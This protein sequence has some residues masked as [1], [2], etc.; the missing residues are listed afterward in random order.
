MFHE[1]NALRDFLAPIKNGAALWAIGFVLL[2]AAWSLWSSRRLSK[3]VDRIRTQDSALWQQ[4]GSPQS[5]ENIGTAR[6]WSTLRRLRV[7]QLF[8]QQF[9]QHVVQEIRSLQ[10]IITRGL[11]VL[12]VAGLLVIYLVWPHR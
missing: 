10:R 4:L 9:N 8:A 3:L 12:S 5:W 7:D 2:V 1:L 6:N 11:V